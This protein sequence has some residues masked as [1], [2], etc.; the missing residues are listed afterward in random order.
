MNRAFTILQVPQQPRK[1]LQVFAAR[2]AAVE[3]QR[4]VASGVIALNDAM[5]N[6]EGSTFMV[7]PTCRLRATTLGNDVG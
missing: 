6:E 2:L 1:T 3:C 4:N 5:S 7:D